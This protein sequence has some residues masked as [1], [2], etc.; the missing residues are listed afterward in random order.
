VTETP[1]PLAGSYYVESLTNKLEAAANDYLAEIDALGGTLAA[2]EAGYQQRQI[3]ESSYQVSE[4]W[5]AAR[6][7]WSG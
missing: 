5:R 3:Q 7:S 2:I 1:D 4:P 6:R